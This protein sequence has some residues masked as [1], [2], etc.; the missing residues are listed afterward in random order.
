MD[1][2]DNSKKLT[3]DEHQVCKCSLERSHLDPL[4]SRRFTGFETRRAKLE[5]NIQLPYGRYCCR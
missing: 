5:Q 1:E 3:V 2:D 4:G